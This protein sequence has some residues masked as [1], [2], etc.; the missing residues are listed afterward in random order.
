MLEWGEFTM[1]QEELIGKLHRL[2]NA[3]ESDKSDV[4]FNTSAFVLTVLPP[5]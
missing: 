4:L 5:N 2:N 3:L 1:L